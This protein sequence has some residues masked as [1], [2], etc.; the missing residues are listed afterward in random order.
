M[1]SEIIGL[2]SWHH[3]SW[4]NGRKLDLA[5]QVGWSGGPCKER[6]PPNSSIIRPRKGNRT[7]RQHHKWYIAFQVAVRWWERTQCRSGM[8]RTRRTRK[9]V[10]SVCGTCL[11]RP[12]WCPVQPGRNAEYKQCSF[13]KPGGESLAFHNCPV[14]ASYLGR[15]RAVYFY[16][17]VVVVCFFCVFFWGGGAGRGGAVGLE[18]YKWNWRVCAIYGKPCFPNCIAEKPLLYRVVISD[19]SRRIVYCTL[20]PWPKG[21]PNSRQVTKSKLASAGGQT[22]PPSRAS[23]QENQPIVWL[24]P[25]SHLTITKQLG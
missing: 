13:L 2:S 12:T 11:W 18:R 4:R 21:T 20:K 6:T 9:R 14:G 8:Q 7:P 3:G 15:G 23:L 1:P 22:I 16:F 19:F 24:R 10:V 17:V 25:R 5:Q